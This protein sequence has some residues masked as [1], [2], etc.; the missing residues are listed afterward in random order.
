[1]QTWSLTWL[2]GC[3][4]F[5]P[6]PGCEEADLVLYFAP[7]DA[8][9]R[10][11]GA[12][13]QICPR[14]KIAGCSSGTTIQGTHLSDTA[15]V[16]LAIKFASSRVEIATTHIDGAT[17]LEAGRRLA[18]NFPRDGLAGLLILSDGLAVN[19]SELV[20]G[21]QD[22][23]GADLPIGGGLAGDGAAFAKTLVGSDGPPQANIVTG[24]GFYGPN[25]SIR[26]GAA[27]GWDFFGPN[28]RVT[29]AEGPVLFELDG[30]PALD[31]Y[32]RYLGDEAQDLPASALL[33]PLL[34]ANPK[35]PQDQ[36]VRTVLAVDRER[37]TMTFAGDIPH[38]WAARL[39]RG[40][41]TNLAAGAAN[42]AQRAL[43]VTETDAPPGLALLVSCV[44][45]RLLMGQRAEDEVEAVASMLGPSFTQYGFYSYGEIATQGVAGWCGLH[46][47]TMTV[48]TMREAA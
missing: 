41:F 28:R 21:L 14:A 31:L 20:T 2:E 16:A 5:Q 23:L 33:Y 29:R 42:A 9:E 11:Y 12:L 40:S 35:A 24:L 27:H 6:E 19:G 48:I 44:G 1:M 10:L 34:I 36:V 25:L 17:S 7:R 22:V 8:I 46:N 32:E 45:R 43:G 37:R 38:G 4:G 30:K 13:H 3:S 18:L 15:P 39:M 47:Q 26:L